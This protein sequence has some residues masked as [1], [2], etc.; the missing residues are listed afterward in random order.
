[1]TIK[2]FTNDN[3][4]N[5]PYMYDYLGVK[6]NFLSFGREVARLLIDEDDRK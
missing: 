1:M 5:G 6:Y 3:G 2:P 4:N